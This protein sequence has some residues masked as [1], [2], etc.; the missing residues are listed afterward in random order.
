MDDGYTYDYRQKHQLIYRRFTFK[1]NEL[2][3]KYNFIFV[4][5]LIISINYIIFILD[6]LI[7]LLNL[8]QM[9]GLNVL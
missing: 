3:S 5:F 7:L 2:H 4:F 9:L 8:I 6:L 1:N